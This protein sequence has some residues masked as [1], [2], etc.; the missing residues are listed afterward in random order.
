MKSEKSLITVNSVYQLISAV[1]I[2]KNILPE[3]GTDILLTDVMP[4]YREYGERLR[5]I[6]VFDN[7]IFGETAELNEKYSNAGEKAFRE[8]L[9]IINEIFSFILSGGLDSYGKIYF[10]NFDVFTRLLGCMYY[11]SDCEFIN[12]EDGF[13]SYV[14]DFLRED[15]CALNRFPD[16]VKIKE[17]LS[18]VLLYEPR[19]SMRG[20]NL[21]NEALPKI[22]K[23][24]RELKEILNYVF[25]YEGLKQR[26]KFI[27]F[28]QSFRRENIKTNDIDLMK[29]CMETAGEENFI[30]KPHPRNIDNIPQK[31]GLTRKYQTSAPWELI[32]MNS[33]ARDKTVITV[34]SN[35]ALSGKLIFGEDINTVMLYR[36][37]NGKVLWKEDAILKRYLR[38]FRDMYGG[39]NYYVPETVYELKSILSYLS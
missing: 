1:N 13:S 36:L 32:L 6:S 39:G 14:I 30:V 10:S 22:N 11:Y 27:F 3:S 4:G 24:D 23:S 38:K 33:D 16:G 29:V 7:V 31:L 21:F 35:A 20:D 26:E 15:R 9:K 19:L 17:K 37:F 34:C 5:E 25:D 28:E 8:A 2:K 18:K 12:Y